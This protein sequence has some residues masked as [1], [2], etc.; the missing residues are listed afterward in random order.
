MKLNRDW[1]NENETRNYPIK[2]NLTRI[3]IAG[4]EIPND[5][6]VD[7]RLSGT[8]SHFEVS[9]TVFNNVDYFI[10][11]IERIGSTSI[12]IRIREIYRETYV[13]GN[14][15]TF[16][17]I[18]E[19][20]IPF[21]SS[22]DQSYVFIPASFTQIRGEIVIR[23]SIDDSISVGIQEFTPDETTLEARTLIPSPGIP[24]VT[25]LVKDGDAFRAVGDV[26]IGEKEGLEVT[27]VESA[28]GLRLDFV[29]QKDCASLQDDE[30]LDAEE[31]TCPM[32]AIMTINQAESD[33]NFNFKV[34]TVTPLNISTLPILKPGG[35]PA[36]PND[37]VVNSLV[38]TY[39]GPI[40]TS[41]LGGDPNDFN[42]Y[43]YG[44]NCT[45]TEIG[46]ELPSLVSQSESML[47][48]LDSRRSFLSLI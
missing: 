15:A 23:K 2:E 28:N 32:P 29:A 18:G 42:N 33:R 35:N 3:S 8:L 6:I 45:H 20:F 43:V 44:L 27:P 9:P 40:T 31:V 17:D 41:F 46:Q 5:F 34:R 24:R 48:V 19:F 4:Y 21:G 1:L 12:V 22:R 36:N 10:K 13:P 47:S 39:H 11:E 26:I 37:Y 25:A 38:V 30:C 14:P 7:L 16:N